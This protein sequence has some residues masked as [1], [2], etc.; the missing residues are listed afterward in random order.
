MTDRPLAELESWL[1]EPLSPAVAES[2]SRLRAADGV[3]KVCLMPD[4]HLASEVCVGAVVA[5]DGVLYPQAVGGDIGCGMAA[6]R[7]DLEASAVDNEQAAG[8]LLAGLY[9]SMP[10]NKHRRARPLPEGLVPEELSDPKLAKIAS[11]DG[12]VQLGTL[13]RG[14]HFLEFQSDQQGQL[15]VMLHS[16]SRGVGQ[17]IAGH[18]TS[19][20]E[21]PSSG[22]VAIEAATNEG[23][24]YLHDAGWARRYAAE[25]RL[26]MLRAVEELLSEQLRG[27]AEWTTLIHADHNHAQ[28]E[29]HGGQELL[30]HRK[31]TQ[32]AAE[33]EHGVVP[34][35][36]G[37][38]SF[39]TMGR[40]C[41]A[42][43]TSCSHGAGR[44]MS[45]TE[46]RRAITPKAFRRQV[47]GLW[48]DHRRADHLRDESPGAYKDIREVMRA[49]KALTKI[50]RELRP[51][52]SYKGV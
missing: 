42:S 23:L 35:S 29:T 24:A 5:T 4:V 46:A 6:L 37:T 2:V 52:L 36:M 51:V 25:N 47:G 3:K 39:H 48:F 32:S 8:Q 18:H 34:G 44:R 31:G 12:A 50:V 38:P 20:V 11:R 19:R 10:S 41:A 13:G 49:Q 43:L 33:N 45:R 27:V 1:T 28:R 17:A 7:F 30:V 40:G 15:W 14:N 9:R 26:A 16:G 22:L 21:S